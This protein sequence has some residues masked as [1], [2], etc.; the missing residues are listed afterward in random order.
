LAKQGNG[1][2]IPLSLPIQGGNKKEDRE[3]A[4]GDS[5]ELLICISTSPGQQKYAHR[6]SVAEGADIAWA[7]EITRGCTME[8][9]RLAESI[10]QL[11]MHS[12]E[13]TLGGKYLSAEHELQSFKK[14]LASNPINPPTRS[15]D[16]R[17]EHRAEYDG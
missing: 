7:G 5:I 13:N 6:R 15:Y 11:P 1:I 10:D 2:S 9:R 8:Y 16:V 4:T 12:D 14:F 3:E 17:Y